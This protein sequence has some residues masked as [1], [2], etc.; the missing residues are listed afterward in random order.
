M[1]GVEV[2]VH[3]DGKV[4]V[5]YDG[6]LGDA[7][8]QEA[9]RIYEQLKALGVNVTIEKVVRTQEAYITQAQKGRV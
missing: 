7:C 9:K 1:K 2:I 4:T 6:F 8:F 3:E 5:R